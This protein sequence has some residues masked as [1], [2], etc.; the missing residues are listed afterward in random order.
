MTKAVA[1]PVALLGG[2]FDPIHY[3]HL[4]PAIELLEQ[5]N[6]GEL[7]LVPGHVP[8]HRPQP[9]LSAQQ[10]CALLAA[11]V[12]DIPGLVVDERELTRPGPS[13]TVDTLREL[14][15]EIGPQRPLIFIMGSDAFRGL[16][17]WH[18]W[19]ALTDYAHLLVTTRGGDAG[20]MPPALSAWLTGHQAEHAEALRQAPAGSVLFQPVSR[21]EISATAIRRLLARG[22]SVRGL[23][24]DAVWH[25]IRQG[26][27][28]YP[29]S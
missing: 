13:Y 27:Y 11:A 1:A 19:Q 14:R 8:P 18:H 6:L 29:Q 4:R 16:M 23:M 20:E 15:S 21:L 3:G 28:G 24:P 26:L 5:L 9:R 22:Y 7:R 2:T 25:A 17:Q 12:A 10:R